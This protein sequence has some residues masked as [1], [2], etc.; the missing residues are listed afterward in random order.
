MYSS[1]NKENDDTYTMNTNTM[2]SNVN[3][4]RNSIM[5]SPAYNTNN[6]EKSP[7]KNR[8]KTI[9]FSSS[10]NNNM[11]DRRVSFGVVNVRVF[12]KDSDLNGNINSP[13]KSPIKEIEK[14]KNFSSPAVLQVYKYNDAFIKNKANNI[15]C[16]CNDSLTLYP[17]VNI[18][19]T[20]S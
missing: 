12:H 17:L 9:N 1:S 19:R 7:A 2:N 5:K 6:N 18:F 10:T 4:R 20:Y 16:V 14:S 15:Q 8:R 3:K 11:I 13:Y